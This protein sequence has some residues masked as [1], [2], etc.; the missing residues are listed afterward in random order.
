[1]PGALDGIKIVDF[2]EY[3]AGPYCT[4]MLA[5]MGADI[6]KIERPDGDAWRHTAPL[7][8]YESRGY[9][10]VNRGKRSIALDLERAEGREITQTLAAGADV[11]VVNYRPG[12]AERLG[13]D[14]QALSAR[15]A[16]LIYCENTAFGRAGPYQG[17]PG[18]DILSQAATGMILYENKIERGVPQFITTVAVADLTTGMFMAFAIVNAL[19]ARAS[20]GK[21][22]LIETS[23]FASGIAA[24]YRPLLS[25]EQRERPVREGFLKELAEAR[26]DGLRFEEAAKLRAQ[27]IQGRGRNNYYRIYETKDGLIAVACLNNRQRRAL[28]DAVGIDDATVEGKSY[29]WFAEEVRSA[30]R[31]NVEAY[32]DAFRAE[33]TEAWLA[34]LDAADVPCGPVNFPEEIFENAHVQA[35]GLIL[36]IDH[37]VLGPL[38][39]PASPIRMSG[40]PPGTDRPPPSLGAHG[41]EVLRELGY[42]DDAIERLLDEGVLHTRERRLARDERETS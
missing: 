23:L 3:I 4:M 37:P 11:V 33:P 34:L 24:Q 17:R 40:T 36:D 19:Y 14:Y 22:Q 13:L 25:I 26:K 30:H 21:G 7:A 16:A 20:T 42:D 29:D 15:N 28:R 31:Q 41:P 10:G 38:K 6:V 32:E 2:T 35:N 27:Y 39:M 9:L 8:P 18:Y 12:V 1:M 5:D